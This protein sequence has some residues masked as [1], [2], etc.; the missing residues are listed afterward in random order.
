[1][2]HTLQPWIYYKIP[3]SMNFLLDSPQNLLVRQ[4]DVCI[5]YISEHVRHKLKVDGENQI[6]TKFGA[7]KA[8]DLIGHPYG[9]KFNLKSGWVLILRL[10]PEL[11]T[12]ILPHRTQILYQA[13][14]SLICAHLDIKPGSVV[15]ESGTGSGSLSHS[16]IRSILPN[17][18]LY[19]FE[20]D[21]QRVFS[22]HKEFQEHGYGGN[23]TVFEKN[24]YIDGF[25]IDLAEKVDA[26][27][28]DIPEPW[29]AIQHAYKVL[30]PDGSRLCTFSIAIEQVKQNVQK[31]KELKLED[32]TT[33][34]CINQPY[35]T[36]QIAFRT[37]ND[38][39]SASLYC[40]SFLPNQSIGHSGFITFASKRPRS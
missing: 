6:Q 8:L 23:V 32:I 10:T 16:I 25:G 14:I 5:I 1:M 30:R 15:V 11:W 2:L 38:R 27:I 33:F 17:G 31:M 3:P 39:E 34:E 26:C 37:W 36:K 24:V 12:Q 40:R 9:T 19:T 7:L 29:N 28:L 4:G 18:F 20:H 21:P 35:S 22:A 13:D